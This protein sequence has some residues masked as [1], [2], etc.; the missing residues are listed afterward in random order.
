MMNDIEIYTNLMVDGFKD[1]PGVKVQF[2]GIDNGFKM[3][4]REYRGV[5]SNVPCAAILKR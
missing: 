5:L 1:D 4:I 3:G 2:E